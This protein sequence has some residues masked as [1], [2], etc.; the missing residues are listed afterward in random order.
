ME[1]TFEFQTKIHISQVRYY[2]DKLVQSLIMRAV[3]HDM[4]KLHE[5]ELS[6]YSKVASKLQ[7]L[8]YGS[9]EYKENLKDLGEALDHHYK[10]NRH[11]PEF[12]ENGINDMNLIDITE[13]LCDWM[14]AIE[15]H[16][17]GN[18]YESLRINKERF[19][20]SDQ[21]YGI[22]KNTV[23]YLKDKVEFRK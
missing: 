16:E 5:P 15:K 3:Y 20:I 17:D 22:L 7:G 10:H 18:I 1:K 8:T 2:I 4:S 19:N 12:F 21:L 13:M 6:I 23:D 14:A 11:H 9:E